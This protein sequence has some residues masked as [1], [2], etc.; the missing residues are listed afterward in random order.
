MASSST[1]RTTPAGITFLRSSGLP[2][3][4]EHSTMSPLHAAG[5]LLSLPLTPSRLPAEEAL[6]EREVPAHQV[7]HGP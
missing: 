7:H 3:L 6:A 1:L 5:S 4:T 2:F